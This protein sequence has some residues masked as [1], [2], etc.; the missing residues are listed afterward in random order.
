[1]APILKDNVFERVKEIQRSKVTI[2]LVE[3]DVSVAIDI[4]DRIYVIA[5]GRIAAE[6]TREELMK[7]TDVREIYL[8]I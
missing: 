3:Q 1:L 7:N 6:G 2:L 4:A 8:G 5:H